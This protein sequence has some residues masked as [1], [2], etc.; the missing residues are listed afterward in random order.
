MKLAISKIQKQ[1]GLLIIGDEILS[2]KT[3]DD[4]IHSIAS[5]LFAHGAKLTAVCV[6]PDNKIFIIKHLKALLKDNDFVITT[7]GIGPTH[8]DITAAA[9]AE[10][11]SL[12]LVIDKTADTLLSAH[13][14]KTGVVYND[15][16]KK[17]AMVP[18]GAKLLP[19]PISLAPGFFVK[20]I[21]VMAGVPRIMKEMLQ[22]ALRFIPEGPKWWQDEVATILGEGAYAKGITA[23]Q[24]KY[25]KVM[26]GS[27]PKFDQTSQK[28]WALLTLK[29]LDK[30]NGIAC[31]KQVEILLKQLEK[32]QL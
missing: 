2:G 10:A 32:N 21:F 18:K 20:R 30:K 3:K 14:A 11:L 24:K 27:Y 15:E 12:P 16:R 8:D 9:V 29:S 1:V 17:M 22:T 26:I 23:I 13:Y 7:G 4:N 31:K 28:L 6:V 19:N 25:P 5:A